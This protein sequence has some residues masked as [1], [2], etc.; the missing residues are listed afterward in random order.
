MAEE[1]PTTLSA[2]EGA[3]RAFLARVEESLALRGVPDLAWTYHSSSSRSFAHG[4]PHTILVA[5]LPGVPG[6]VRVTAV[7]ALRQLVTTRPGDG[8]AM[9]EQIRAHARQLGIAAVAGSYRTH[10]PFPGAGVPEYELTIVELTPLGGA[11]DAGDVEGR[12]VEQR[13]FADP[14]TVAAEIVGWAEAMRRSTP[15]GPRDRDA[16]KALRAV[17]EARRASLV[18]IDWSPVMARQAAGHLLEAW[19]AAGILA[20]FDPDDPDAG[21]D[22]PTGRPAT[23]PV[24]LA[25]HLARRFASSGLEAIVDFGAAADR[26]GQLIA[27]FPTP[28]SEAPVP[29]APTLTP[30]ARAALRDDLAALDLRQLLWHLPRDGRGRLAQGERVL[31]APYESATALGQGRQIW[32]VAALPERRRDP[33]VPTLR[34][35]SLIG[36]NHTHRWDGARWLWDTRAQGVAIGERWGIAKLPL[37][38]TSASAIGDGVALTPEGRASRCLHLQDSG[39]FEA[40]LALYGVALAPE[41]ARLVRGESLG[42]HQRALAEPWARAVQEAVREAALWR[43]GPLLTEAAATRARWL[44]EK[45]GRKRPLPALRLLRLPKQTGQSKAVLTLA[46]READGS[47]PWLTLEW[48]GADDRLPAVAWHRDRD[49]DLLRLG[50]LTPADLP[51]PV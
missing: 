43:F 28:A 27:T 42:W 50:L 2:S 30:A 34:L 5:T 12:P 21:L 32:L 9:L 41:V 29:T 45:R 48:T 51:Y 44:A 36:A 22:A 38:E 31:L 3:R 26:L 17:A 23:P 24:P 10:E 35:V 37:P 13:H 33:Q 15:P 7:T 14:A 16:I 46:A 47:Q 25:E 8:D 49:I 11:T 4:T 18:N 19:Q 39:Q 6:E 40:A 20:G 1:I